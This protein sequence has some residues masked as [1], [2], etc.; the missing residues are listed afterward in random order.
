MNRLSVVMLVLVSHTAMAD[1]ARPLI[2]EVIT[3]VKVVRQVN[4]AVNAVKP[5]D[6]KNAVKVDASNKANNAKIPVIPANT[7][8][9][10]DV[11]NKASNAKT[12]QT[13]VKV[14]TNSKS[15]IAKPTVV[16]VI[17]SKIK[18]DPFALTVDELSLL[19][20][21]TPPPDDDYSKLATKCDKVIG[22]KDCVL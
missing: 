20:N 2:K 7:A 10:T 4:N 3:Q 6:D 21:A 8:L 1:V 11:L 12:Q 22:K 13:T 19:R 15:P 17:T 16:P 18:V 9:K 14:D 5:N